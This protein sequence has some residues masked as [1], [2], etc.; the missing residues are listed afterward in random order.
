[1]VARIDTSAT[2]SDVLNYNEKKVAQKDAV[3][4]HSNGFLKDANHLNFYEKEERFQRLNELNNRSD[5]NTLH[6]NLNFD[7]SEQLTDA[8][9]S[10]IADRY[11]QGIGMENQPYLVY[12]HTDAGHPHV[13]IVSSLI[14][15]NGKR[16]KTN[17]IGKELSGP[18]RKAI[19]KEFNLVRASDR[20]RQAIYQVKPVDVPKVIYGNTQE[21]KKAMRNVLLMANQNYK[22]TSLPEYNAI[23]RQWNVYADRGGKN[24]R[25]YKNNGL[26]YRVIDEKG[27]RKGVPIKASDYFFKPTLANLEKKFEQHKAGRLEDLPKMQQKIDEVLD[28]RPTSLREFTGALQEKGIEAIVYQGEGDHVYGITFVDNQLR[29]AVKGSDLGK[30]YTAGNLLKILSQGQTPTLS[31]GQQKTPAKGQT[32]KT[33][34]PTSSP[35]NTASQ[36]QPS[37]PSPETSLFDGAP[38]SL[39]IPQVLSDLM[40]A[41]PS[42]GSN[43]HELQEDQQLRKRPRR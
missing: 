20:Q 22:F 43:P 36:G 33:Q 15:P 10:R 19:E 24:S 23:L 11:M 16:V 29:T 14:R 42:Y 9:L 38:F 40:A 37:A 32:S 4:I 5:V 25:I 34:G 35:G 31:P 6:A 30:Q 2:L 8:Q 39:K 26:V 3:L 13:H 12:R 28:Q 1:M 17:N 27:K 41:N 7:P 18:I 21:T